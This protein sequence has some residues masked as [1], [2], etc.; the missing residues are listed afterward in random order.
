[1]ADAVLADMWSDSGPDDDV[2]LVCPRHLGPS[3]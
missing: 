2:V 1:M 3:G